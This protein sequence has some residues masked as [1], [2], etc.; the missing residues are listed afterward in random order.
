MA[1][2]HVCPPP[3]VATCNGIFQGSNPFDYSLPLVILQ[4]CLVVIIT[5]TLAFLK[6]L[7][8]EYCLGH[9]LWV[10]A[11]YIWIQ[12]CHPEAS[13]YW[14]LANLGLL[15]FL[16]LVDLELDPT[17]LR[18]TGKKIVAI[19]ITGISVPFALGIGSSFV[20][21]Q[22]IS[23]GVHE[24]PFIVFMGV[25]MSITSFPV[26]AR[27]FAELKLLTTGV[28]R[29]AIPCRCLV[30]HRS[31]CHAAMVSLW[32]FLV[33]CCLLICAT[34][35]LPPFFKW[36]AKHCEEGE[37]VDELYICATLVVVL[38]IGFITDSIGIHALFGA[39]VV[40][41]LVPKDGPFSGDLVE[42]LEDQVGLKTNVG[43]IQGA[44]SWGLLALVIFTACA[45]KILDAIVVSLLYRVPFHEALALGFLMNNKGL[46]ELIVINI[47]RDRKPARRSNT[48]Y[49]YRTIDRK[50]P[51][52]QLWILA[53]Y[54]STKSIPTLV[55]LIERP[56]AILMANK[57]RKNRLPFWS[58]GR[59]M[60]SDPVVAA[61]K[62]FQRISGV[63]M[64][65]RPISK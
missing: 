59:R 7:R 37:P 9:Q 29:L 32:V 50:D 41:L 21:T 12:F 10:V 33:V 56:S 44:Q 17:F 65:V 52:T 42:K 51:S 3:L 20:L 11:R 53:C 14:T 64:N 4:I 26:L 40:G 15:F 48:E 63:S 25:A 61:F 30:N 49:K 54:H 24:P 8:V 43:T 22:T 6:P 35:V 57:T 27:I 34:I 36:M 39:F 38:V 19:A 60:G 47:G 23:K 58:K 45:G 46:V 1:S 18:R 16:F 13:L 5:R 31:T 55:K 2:T 62:A 28:G